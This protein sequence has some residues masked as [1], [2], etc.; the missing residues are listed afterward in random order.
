MCQWVCAWYLGKALLTFFFT[1]DDWSYKKDHHF[2]ALPVPIWMSLATLTLH[3]LPLT[4]VARYGVGIVT[5]KAQFLNSLPK[6]G[7]L[8]SCSL[9]TF[10]QTHT[11][12]F[13]LLLYRAGKN[14]SYCLNSVRI[15]LSQGTSLSQPVISEHR[16]HCWHRMVSETTSDLADRACAV[17]ALCQ[18]VTSLTRNK[19]L[20]EML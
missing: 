12:T 11:P 9:L 6:S 7:E 4:M 15:V 17:F 3:L 13:S 5:Q 14:Q 16:I 20:L 18:S 8:K 19:R 10:L 1:V 2:H